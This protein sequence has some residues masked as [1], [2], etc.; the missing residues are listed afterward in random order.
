MTS[1]SS[2]SWNISVTMSQPPTSFPST[3]SCGIVGPPTSPKH[4]PDARV[5]EDV[6]RPVLHAEVVEDLDHL[7]GEAA[8]GHLGRALHVEEDAV[9][10]DLALDLVEDLLLGHRD[11]VGH[12]ASGARVLRASAWMLPSS[13]RLCTAA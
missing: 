4:D 6:A 9:L 3:K 11:G 1:W 13:S 8:A 5:D 7:V 12:V 2:P 10:S